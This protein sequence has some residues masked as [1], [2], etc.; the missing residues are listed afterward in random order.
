MVPRRERHDISEPADAADR[1]EPTLA[2][3]PIEKA[4]SADPIDPIDSTDPTDPIDST[5]PLLAM[6]S[7]E[8]CERYDHRFTDT[9]PSWRGWGVPRQPLVG[10]RRIGP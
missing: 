3:D 8:S 4:D 7:T 1:M 2:N 10:G 5:D 9:A 6:L